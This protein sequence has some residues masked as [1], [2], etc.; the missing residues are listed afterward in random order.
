MFTQESSGE[1]AWKA[2][3]GHPNRMQKLQTQ[4]HDAG[5]E[6]REPRRH[7]IGLMIAKDGEQT[8]PQN[9]IEGKKRISPAH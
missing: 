4:E 5:E 7:K 3:P 2:S 8:I 9:S 1:K 6:A